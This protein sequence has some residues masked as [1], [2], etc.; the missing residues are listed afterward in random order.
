MAQRMVASAQLPSLPEG[1]LKIYTPIGEPV[2]NKNSVLY[3]AR[4][5]DES[6]V[7]IKR[8]SLTGDSKLWTLA[9]REAN[10]LKALRTTR[11]TGVLRHLDHMVDDA[12]QGELSFY[13]ITEWADGQNLQQFIENGGILENWQLRQLMSRCL[14]ILSELH[15]LS[16]PIIHRD[17][18]PANLMLDFDIAMNVLLTL[19]D[20]GFSLSR[21]SSGTTYF[22]MNSHGFTAPEVAQGL[23]GSPKSDLYS[24][25]A[26]YLWLRTK[27]NPLDFRDSDG[28]KLVLPETLDSQ[29]KKFITR[30]LAV[31]P[32][33]RFAS[34]K[35]MWEALNE[36]LPENPTLSLQKL[37]PAAAVA[38][39]TGCANQSI[40]TLIYMCTKGERK[41]RVHYGLELVRECEHEKDWKILSRLAQS[42]IGAPFGKKGLVIRAPREVKREAQARLIG[43]A[44]KYFEALKVYGKYALDIWAIKVILEM[45]RNPKRYD[46]DCFELQKKYRVDWGVEL[47]AHVSKKIEELMANS[48]PPASSLSETEQVA[49]QKR[50]DKIVRLFNYELGYSS[51]YP[52]ELGVVWENEVQRLR[53]ISSKYG[54]IIDLDRV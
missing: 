37:D 24:V 43:T 6:R 9:E 52:K 10:L 50:I 23:P 25:A 8:T 32:E 39:G 1:L 26:I 34:A 12:V 46:S 21:D 20:F 4:T 45:L 41:L 42:Y 35:E 7:A 16:D 13:L 31:D 36:I 40:D 47:L 14:G 54:F 18:K 22:A 29:T 51:R 49:L 19:I 53:P 33:S 28:S 3:Q 11:I 15:S 44:R 38:E 2:R 30:G 17:L 27:T 48:V 5:G